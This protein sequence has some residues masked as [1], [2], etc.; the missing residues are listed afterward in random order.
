M[1]IVS[2][3]LKL[4]V[5]DESMYQQLQNNNDSWTSKIWT[6]DDVILNRINLL[7]MHKFINSLIYCSFALVSTSKECCIFLYWNILDNISGWI[8]VHR[9]CSIDFK[10]VWDSNPKCHIK[11]KPHNIVA[12]EIRDVPKFWQRIQNM[13]SRTHLIV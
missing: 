9:V 8:S 7:W 12:Y 11:R 5:E 2:F 10:K 4:H 6:F 13:T 3:N 1:L